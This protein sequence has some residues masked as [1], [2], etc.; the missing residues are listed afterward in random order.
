MGVRVIIFA[1]LTAMAA[2]P[3][4]KKRALQKFKLEYTRT[5]PV[6]IES[7][8]KGMYFARCNLCDIDFSISHGGRD[9]C[10]DTLSDSDRRRDE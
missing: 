10:S 2:P 1:F 6:L 3:A 4:R 5:W 7:V 8:K 9:D